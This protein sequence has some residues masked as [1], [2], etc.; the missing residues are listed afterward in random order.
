MTTQAAG[1]AFGLLPSFLGRVGPAY[2]RVDHGGDA[3]VATQTPTGP[4]RTGGAST[5]RRRP[6]SP[7]TRSRPSTRADR[8]V[9]QPAGAAASQLL[10]KSKC[11][12]QG[13]AVTQRSS[14]M[15]L[16]YQTYWTAPGDDRV[17][18]RWINRFY[19]SVY[20]A[21][22]GVPASNRVTDGCFINYPDVN[23]RPARRPLLQG[24]LPRP[25]GGQGPL[26]SAKRV[27]PRPSR[28]P[29]LLPDLRLLPGRRRLPGRKRRVVFVI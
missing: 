13:T 4:G 23:L 5:S 26:G 3:P 8:R 28:S 10:Q 24:R 19:A 1:P 21:S 22:G 15:K 25:A 9:T 7:M 17:N 18:L 2:R 27:P 29:R 12:G 11:R 6:S 16:Q 20:A 14:I